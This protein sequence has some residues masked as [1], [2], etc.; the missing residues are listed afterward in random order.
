ML[1]VNRYLHLR[2]INPLIV[3]NYL[4]SV[5]E[6]V[7]TC[8]ES[9]ERGLLF[10]Y[11][12][13]RGGDNVGNHPL[14]GHLIHPG[15]NLENCGHALYDKKHQGHFSCGGCMKDAISG[16]VSALE[17]SIMV[18]REIF[19]RWSKGCSEKSHIKMPH[20]YSLHLLSAS[21]VKE[22]IKMQ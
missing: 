19:G 4:T 1:S 17:L 13:K 18:A 22:I 8:G 21:F 16:T 9:V 7:R 3:S 2:L 15:K 10:F 20:S 11:T 14:N 5:Y 12:G 6:L